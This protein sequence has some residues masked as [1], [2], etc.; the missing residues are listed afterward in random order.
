MNPIN[1][2]EL[3]LSDLESLATYIAKDKVSAAKKM[4]LRIRE[5]VEQIALQPQIGRAGKVTGTRELVIA[6]TPYLIA[7]CL[8]DH[9][10]DIL[11]VIHGARR[12]P[13]NFSNIN[14]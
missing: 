8:T 10:V 7:Y 11:A 5:A 6:G 1:W 9:G 12:W 3:A 2:T 14:D 13:E 4:V